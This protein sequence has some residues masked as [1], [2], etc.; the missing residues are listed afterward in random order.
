MFP[1]LSLSLS[2]DLTTITVVA[3]LHYR[4]RPPVVTHHQIATPTSLSPPFIHHHQ[5]FGLFFRSMPHFVHPHNHRLWP[6]IPSNLRTSL[7]PL[8]PEHPRLWIQVE[9]VEWTRSCRWEIHTGE[10][11]KTT[12]KLDIGGHQWDVVTVAVKW[13]MAQKGRG[14]RERERERNTQQKTVCEVTKIPML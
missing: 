3:D 9:W 1:L 14:E 2:T 11:A 7:S 10:T 12:P 8:S 5:G 6:S 13:T 4:Q